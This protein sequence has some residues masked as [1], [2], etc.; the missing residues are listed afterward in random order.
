MRMTIGIAAALA[1]LAAPAGAQELDDVV[2]AFSSTSALVCDQAFA[3]DGSMR[4][5]P[6]VYEMTYRTDWDEPGD[7]PRPLVLYR[8][9]CSMGA[10]NVGHV[11]YAAI[12]GDPPVPL[13]FAVPSYDVS[14]RRNGDA[15]DDAAVESITLTGFATWWRL[16]NSEVDAETGT[17]TSH[18]Y[19]RGLGDASSVGTWTLLEGDVSLVRFEIDASYDGEVAPQLVWEPGS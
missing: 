9:F 7:P 2:A 12:D 5:P 6:E 8:L 18:S 15:V 14:Y 13:H 17:I 10:Y 19:W 11:F 16:T 3:E 1:A 4:E